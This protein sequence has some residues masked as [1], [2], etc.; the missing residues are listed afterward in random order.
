MNR[1]AE[2]MPPPHTGKMSVKVSALCSMPRL[3]W[4]DFWAGCLDI[5]AKRRIP[6]RP[7][8]G[9]A[10]W[11]QH[12]QQAMQVVVDAGVD[13]IITLDYDSMFNVDQL[14]VL[15]RIMATHPEID[16]VFPMMRRR[17][18][19]QACGVLHKDQVIERR[20]NE[21]ED[22]AIIRAAFSSNPYA[23]MLCTSGHFGFTILRAAKIAAMPQ[24]WFLALP[25]LSGAYINSE[26]GDHEDLRGNNIDTMRQCAGVGD[27]VPW[28]RIDA[29]IY[30]WKMWERAGNSV[31]VAP[32][33]RIAHLECYATGF[34]DQMQ[35]R[36]WPVD[37]WRKALAQPGN[38]P[39]T[40]GDRHESEI[41]KAGKAP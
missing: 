14:D 12:L 39:D 32:N 7:Y 8:I 41:C 34:D 26:K 28:Q 30:F 37:E 40:M 29:D 5:L 11:C 16:A 38:E 17:N 19:E 27:V 2:S 3:G 36:I 4:N 15:L 20:V 25:N 35:P 24:P 31:H 33:V 9:G 22:E 23:T 18:C 21:A 10:F 13:W 1:S 6:V